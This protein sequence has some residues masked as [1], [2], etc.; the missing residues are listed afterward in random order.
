MYCWCSTLIHWDI[1][2]E[3]FN[4]FVILIYLSL[5]DTDENGCKMD[6]EVFSE[7]NVTFKYEVFGLDI[8]TEYKIH[9]KA[10][11]AVGSG[12]EAS[13][14][15]RTSEDSKLRDEKGS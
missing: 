8:F 13:K 3:Y 1:E 10:F 15:N 5:Q 6:T 14:R 9:V 7:S 2:V 11:T 4:K 12:P